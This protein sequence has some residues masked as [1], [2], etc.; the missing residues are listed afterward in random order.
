[1]LRKI[2]GTTGTRV[3]NALF[4]LIN[5][6]L[7]TNFIGKEG[8]G[9]IGI[10]I[11]DISV[12]QIIFDFVAGSSIIYFASRA[13][14]WQLFIPALI[15]ILIIS[16]II[17]LAHKIIF[18]ASP[19]FAI[20]LIPEGY[21]ADIVV[22]TALNG[23]M[24]INYNLLLGRGKVLAY[25]IL[26][27][28]QICSSLTVFLIQLLVFNNH[29]ID[30]FL[31]GL[32][33]GYGIS[34]V[35]GLFVVMHKSGK[36]KLKGWFNVTKKVLNYGA[37][38]I[39]GNLLTIGNNRLS[40][41]IIRYFLGLPILGI[42]TAGVQLSEGLK[43]IGQ[44]L[45]V[46]QF[47]TIANT[48]DNEYAR[49]LTIRF[50]KI[51]VIITTLALLAL[52]LL[53]QSIYSLIL[54]KDFSD[55]KTLIIA[56]APGVIALATS[57]IFSH[58]FS[59]L[60]NPKVNVYAKITGLIITL[61]LVFILIPLYGI[62]GAAITASMSYIATAAHQYIVFVKHTKTEL[63]EWLPSLDDYKALKQII[64]NKKLLKK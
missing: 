3:L 31:S 53:P 27:T 2:I 12:I 38:T 62:A 22:L 42:Y 13:N 63:K 24:V 49:I 36:I 57:N 10:I 6:Y 56:L 8:M 34:F 61:A 44:S 4:A 5:L 7:L 35:S 58:Y 43:V 17:V 26:F 28:V 19:S 1:M 18:L 21:L 29:S 32:Y 47:S 15:W 33:F 45:A 60:G 25:N 59:G 52:I 55:V 64:R 41:Y 40:Y 37:I 11:L 50:M 54:T 9:I 20:L 48:R 39:S 14:R 16:F 46:V 23:L 51:A 30:A